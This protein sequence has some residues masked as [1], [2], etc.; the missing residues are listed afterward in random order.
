VGWQ[1]RTLFTADVEADRDVKEALSETEKRLGSL[2]DAIVGWVVREVEAQLRDSPD[3]NIGRAE[4]VS[5]KLTDPVSVVESAGQKECAYQIR[6]AR[7]LFCV[8]TNAKFDNTAVLSPGGRTQAPTSK[9]YAERA[10]CP[11][12]IYFAPD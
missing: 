7:D 12:R 8:A 9:V 1:G 4:F 11:I 5:F 10:I 3:P 2:H 6:E